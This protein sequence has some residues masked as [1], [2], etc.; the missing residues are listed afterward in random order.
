[1]WGYFRFCLQ[2]SQPSFSEIQLIIKFSEKNL[3]KNKFS[4]EV[5]LLKVFHL[6]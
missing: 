6:Y 5:K 2:F 4:I 3:I 1:M